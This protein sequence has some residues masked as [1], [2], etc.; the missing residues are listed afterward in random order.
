[1]N[2][3]KTLSAVAL[4]ALS[5]PMS[6]PV[7]AA[8]DPYAPQIQTDV[9]AKQSRISA[10]ETSV[11]YQDYTG[12]ARMES[13]IQ[14]VMRLN[15]ITHEEATARYLSAIVSQSG[16][17]GLNPI[18]PASKMAFNPAFQA[19]MDLGGNFYAG[20]D[21]LSG[22]HRMIQELR[23]KVRMDNFWYCPVGQ[24]FVYTDST[25]TCQ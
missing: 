4:T 7:L 24:N 14:E 12:A 20:F 23:A 19:W 2:H 9:A 13:N 22:T 5:L 6:A 17:V 1:M 18:Y 15:G 21:P 8:T 3:I 25:S 11:Q 10:Y 16:S